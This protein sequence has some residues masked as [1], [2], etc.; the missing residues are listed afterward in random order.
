MRSLFDEGFR[1]TTAPFSP[2]SFLQVGSC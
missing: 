1:G 2:A